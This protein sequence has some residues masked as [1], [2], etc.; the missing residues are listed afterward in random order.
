[1]SVSNTHAHRPEAA[2]DDDDED[3][4]VC[5]QSVTVTQTAASRLTAPTRVSVGVEAERQEGAVTPVCPD[6]P[7]EAAE[8]AQVHIP[9]ACCQ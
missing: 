2:D 5:P 3:V 4:C 6:T 7:G 1:M 9:S 8:S